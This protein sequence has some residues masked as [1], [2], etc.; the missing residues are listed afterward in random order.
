MSGRRLQGR[1]DNRSIWPLIG[2][3]HTSLAVWTLQNALQSQYGNLRATP[4][5]HLGNHTS[6]PSTFG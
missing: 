6:P 3:K 2:T 5:Q 1:F 4:D